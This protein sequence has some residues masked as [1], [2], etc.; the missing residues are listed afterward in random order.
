MKAKVDPETC[1]GCEVCVTL[2]PEVFEMD[3]SIAIVKEGAVPADAESDCQEAK[4]TCPV[5]AITVET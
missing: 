5:D 4:D 2:C 1:I 3:E